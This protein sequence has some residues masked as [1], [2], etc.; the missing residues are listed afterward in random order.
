VIKAYV[1]MLSLAAIV[2]FVCICNFLPS[3]A[4]FKIKVAALS[5]VGCAAM[6][7]GCALSEQPSG[8]LVKYLL[9]LGTAFA[10]Y[11]AATWIDGIYV[12][13]YYRCGKSKRSEVY[14]KEIPDA[15]ASH[16]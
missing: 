13:N 3:T 1:V 14:S 7:L 4:T 11:E 5:C 8:E 10:L 9:M 2:H 16:E 15:K 12:C 6:L